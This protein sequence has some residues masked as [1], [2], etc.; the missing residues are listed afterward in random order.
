[1][2]WVCVRGEGASTHEWPKPAVRDEGRPRAGGG[3]RGRAGSWEAWKGR[4]RSLGL[5][6]SGALGAPRSLGRGMTWSGLGSGE[7]PPTACGG[8]W[9]QPEAGSQ[10][11]CHQA[12]SLPI[13]TPTP[14]CTEGG[15]YREHGQEWT[16]PG[17][18]CW[19]C[20]CL[21]SPAAAPTPQAHRIH[22]FISLSTSH[23]PWEGTEVEKT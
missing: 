20:Q 4:L 13:F 12:S 18:P 15:S 10:A 5:T 14:G 22:S 7:S 1:M 17:D 19:I 6:L 9:G 8:R 2:R 11:G 21:V 3:G 16:A 23:R